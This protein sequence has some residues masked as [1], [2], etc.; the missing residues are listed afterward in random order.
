M[1]TASLLVVLAALVLV[2]GPP[3]RISS[4]LNDAQRRAEA[5][6]HFSAGQDSMHA[7]AF[8]RA[9]REFKAA[10]ELDPQLVLA[11]YN[12]GQAHMALKQYP[13]AVQAYLGCRQ[14]IEHLNSLQQGQIVERDHEIDDQIHDL[15]DLIRR[16]RQERTADPG[17][18]IMMIEERIRVLEG[19]RGKGNDRHA[20]V[21][22]E[23]YLAL[24]S[25]Y[26]R[27]GALAD[28]E[29]EYA[30]AIKSDAKLG[31]AHN[32]LAVIYMLSGRYKE[33]RVALQKAEK[34]GFPV[35]PNLKRDLEAREA[36]SH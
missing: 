26:Y 8:E 28:A 21:P 30:E 14:A 17:N 1:P 32:N 29:R 35:N 12:L 31:P 4:P 10:I 24:G 25:A 6:Q 16:V 19:I 18:K 3:N 5:Q 15:R 7:E 9:V 20:R 33:A 36:A 13:E 27:Q 23:L 11:H 2:D 34:S 22:A